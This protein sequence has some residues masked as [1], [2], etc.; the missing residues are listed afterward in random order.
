MIILVKASSYGGNAIRYAMEKERAEVITRNHL[1]EGLTATAI[2]NR[3]R[4]HC[5][6]HRSEHTRGRPMQHFMVTFVISPSPDECR[7]WSSR[8][9]AL[10]KRSSMRSMRWTQAACPMQKV[11]VHEFREQHERERPSP[12]Q[13]IGYPA[14]SSGCLP[15][16]HGRSHQ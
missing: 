1:P 10:A 5:L 15:P 2:W 8:D 12:R 14:P 11:Q 9:F 4:L 6:Q 3:M 7:G 13:Q 16:G